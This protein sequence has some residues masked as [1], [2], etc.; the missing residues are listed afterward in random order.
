MNP[1]CSIP[2]IILVDDHHVF[3]Q[4]IKS[5]LSIESIATVIGE[6]ANGEEFIELLSFLKPDLVLMDIN[7]P[8]MN[9]FEATK[10]ALEIMPGIKIIAYTMFGD[11]EYCIR[12]MGLGVKGVILKSSGINE[13]EEAIQCVLNGEMYLNNKSLALN[14][15][16][17]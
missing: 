2:D 13:L 5:I 7:M 4:S 3:R 10:K 6:A 11:D 1:D 17:L 8:R 15:R 14:Y 16:K 12:M 9:G